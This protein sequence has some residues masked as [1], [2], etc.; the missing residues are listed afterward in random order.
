M[1]FKIT[2]Y[3]LFAVRFHEAHL[4][5][6]QSKHKIAHESY[7]K[8]L[9]DPAVTGQLRADIL[10]QLG[11]LHHTVE[12]LGEKREREEKAV[13]LLQKSIEA[14]PKSGQS[15]YLLGRCL[16]SL[17]KIHEA[18]VAYRNS[19]DKCEGNADTWC[20]IGWVLR[21]AVFGSG[22]PMNFFS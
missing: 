9:N 5:E 21:P 6:L 22:K 16:A 14:D 20:S 2:F 11:W 3:I 8:L 15:L 17:G 7:E 12:A 13:S 4:F 19:V 10:R 18:F 1:I